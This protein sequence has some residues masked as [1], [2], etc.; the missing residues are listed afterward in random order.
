MN[1]NLARFQEKIGVDDD[2]VW[3]AGTLKAAVAYYKLTPIRGAHFFA[4]C[5]HE[6][7]NFSLFVENL[8]YNA[9]ALTATWPKRFNADNAAQ[10][11][12]QPEKI[13]NKVYGGRLGNGEES[14]GDGWKFRG[15]GAIQLT[16]RDNYK[17]FADYMKK[18]EI[19]QNPDLVSADYPIE[20]ALFF[21]ER[22][23]LWAICDSGV[24]DASI[25][26]LTEKINGGHIGLED[27]KK[28][29]YEYAKILK[30]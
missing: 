19:V 29:T 18:P 6:S 17:A 26:K 1:Q 2:G 4:Q 8:N 11:A 3:G 12:R 30:A 27:R 24:N 10:Y 5:A 15:R 25:T 13:A 28:N 20:S 21:F 7:G 22:N 23:N 16:G 14:T 9:S